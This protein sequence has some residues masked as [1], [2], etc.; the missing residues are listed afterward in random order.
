[1][2]P[3]NSKKAIFCRLSPVIAYTL[4][5]IYAL[6]YESS[7]MNGPLVAQQ[8]FEVVLAYGKER[9]IATLVPVGVPDGNPPV[10]DRKILEEITKVIG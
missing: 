3:K 7:W 8:D 1:V 2:L 4:L 9:L 6:G 10:R 5:A